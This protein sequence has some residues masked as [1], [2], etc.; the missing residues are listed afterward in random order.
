LTPKDGK[1]VLKQ[2][3][4]RI[5]QTQIEVLWLRSPPHDRGY[6]MTLFAAD[7]V[8][9]AGNLGRGGL[10]IRTISYAK[11]QQAID[12]S[13]IAGDTISAFDMQ[14]GR[15]CNKRDVSGGRRGEDDS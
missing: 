13:T 2:I 1:T 8:S 4:E 15:R 3:H 6:V 9:Y 14:G 12:F 7:C 10:K 11:G 5:V